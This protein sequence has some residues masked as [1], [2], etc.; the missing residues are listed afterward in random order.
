MAVYKGPDGR[1]YESW[2]VFMNVLIDVRTKT[3]GRLWIFWL[4]SIFNDVLM[5]VRIK[6]DNFPVWILMDILKSVL[7]SLLMKADGLP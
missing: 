1:P 5:D 3:D 2:W 7:V 4:T 6:T